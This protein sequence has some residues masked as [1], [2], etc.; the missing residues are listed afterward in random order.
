MDTSYESL[1][2]TVS[3]RK[4]LGMLARASAGAM[5]APFEVLAGAPGRKTAVVV[6]AG[7]AGLSAAWELQRAG[8]AT[9]VLEKSAFAGGRMRDAWVGK[10]RYS[11]HALGVSSYNREMFALADEI[12]IAAELAGDSESDSYPVDNGIGV[13]ASGLRF[14]IAEIA[15]IPG[16]AE[17]TRR[18]LPRLLPDLAAIAREV[19]P[20]LIDTG[21]SYDDESLADYYTRQL[22]PES[23][24][25]VLDWWINVVLE[26]AGWPAANTSKIALLM[27]LAQEGARFRVPK[28]GIGVLTR[29]LADRLDVRLGHAVRYITPPN[30]QGRHTLHYLTPALERRSLTPDVVVV[31]TEGKYIPSLVQGLAPE[32]DAFFRGM[33]FSKACGAIWVLDPRRAPMLNDAMG[34]TRSHPDPVKRQV[35]IWSVSNPAAYGGDAPPSASVNLTREAV[36][37]WQDSGRTQQDYCLPLL[38]QLCPA[39]HEDMITDVIVTG[40][41]DLVYMPVG[42]ARQAARLLRVQERSRRGIYFAG[43]FVSGA[44]TGAACASGRTV[45]RSIVRHWLA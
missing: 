17:E 6:G 44:H 9:L 27:G 22:G 12:G 38:L 26:A 31:A 33:D 19:D 43:E 8:F 5:L 32:D 16:I 13:Y 45:A 29:A 35:A 15:R 25:Q 1:P 10:L 24:R 14:D 30:A 21:A 23:A 37:E 36:F 28:G 11:P 4:V 34:Y 42:H 7:I 39:L 2:A 40:C 41:D 3:R 18:R 20:C